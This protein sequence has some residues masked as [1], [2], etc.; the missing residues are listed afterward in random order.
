[1]L[2]KTMPRLVLAAAALA[3]VPLQAADTAPVPAMAA[4]LAARVP[5]TGMAR[6]GDALVAVG[7]Y[8][9]AIRSTDGG[10][11]W[12]QA[13]VP[14]STLLTA[15]HFADASNGWAVGHGG[16]VLA[17]RDGGAT[18]ALQQVLDGKPVLLSVYF[19]SAGR[20]YAVGAYGSAWRTADGG[21]TWAPMMVGSGADA[22]MHLNHLFAAPGGALY[23]AAESGLAFR[24]GDGGDTWTT[25]R[26]GA[27]GSLWSGLAAGDEI[28]LLGMSGRVLAS[29]DGGGHWRTLDSGTGQ[30]LTGAVADAD[31][32]LTVVGAGGAV[33]RGGHD[34]LAAE[35]RADRQNLAAVLLAPDGGVVVGGQLGVERLDPPR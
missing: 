32:R 31:G 25:L 20:G 2:K 1:M 8:G 10:R 15:V 9:T 28:L 13:A 23:I 29:R 17:S 5:V 12:Q 18:W 19:E 16:V 22:D 7:D 27:S 4:R 6:A 33:L 11:T 24:S 34:R 21:A 30:S 14:V 3:A 35:V 26:P